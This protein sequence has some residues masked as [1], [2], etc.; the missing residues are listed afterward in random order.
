MDGLTN[1]QHY[2]VVTVLLGLNVSANLTQDL[3]IL[4][5]YSWRQDNKNHQEHLVIVKLMLGQ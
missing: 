2:L 3:V 1:L 5:V 4:F